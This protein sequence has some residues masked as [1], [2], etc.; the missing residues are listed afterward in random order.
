MKG[1]HGGSL[2]LGHLLPLQI[3][4]GQIVQLLTAV[5]GF[6]A[7]ECLLDDPACVL[8]LMLLL[9]ATNC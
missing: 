1:L 3:S 9:D 2:Q 7:A 4:H 8:T 5:S 6:E